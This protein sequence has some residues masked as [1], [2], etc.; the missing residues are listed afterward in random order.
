MELPAGLLPDELRWRVQG[1]LRTPTAEIMHE[2][3]QPWLFMKM[4]AM[5][6]CLSSAEKEGK[7]LHTKT[8]EGIKNFIDDRYGFY[9]YQL[10]E[11]EILC[12]MDENDDDDDEDTAIN[13]NLMSVLMT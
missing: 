3:I 11:E 6:D 12:W 2:A 5:N 9:N 8:I 10:L 7:E 13:E 4:S 1:F